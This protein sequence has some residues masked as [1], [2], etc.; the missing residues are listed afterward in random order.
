MISKQIKKHKS[1]NEYIQAS[2]IWVRNFA[3]EAVMPVAISHMFD[4]E[5][6]GPILKND[7]MNTLFPK[8]SNEKI[9]FDKMVIVSDGYKFSERHKFLNKLTKDVAIIAVNKALNKWTLMSPKLP[10]SEKRTINA[11]VINNPY[12]ECL[13]CLPSSD[14]K[15]Y[16]T[17]VASIRANYTFLRKY[18]GDVYTYVPTSETLF[19]LEHNESY[20]IDDYRNPICAAIGLAYQFKVKKLLL[21]CCDDSFEEERAG[22]IKLK[23]GLYTYPQHVKSQEI[24]D[25]NLH[26]L[27]NQENRKVEV[28]NFSSGGDYLNATYI[29]TEEQA[30]LFFREQEEEPPNVK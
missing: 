3:K 11:F 28:A 14:S 23:N 30:L 15:Y 9:I 29:N 22:S 4:K 1:G 26:W 27:T 12:P 24:I 8:I 5:D 7:Q 20:Y 2:K 19:G 13:S 16:P 21:L 17:C 10:T 6:Y 18:L 25:A